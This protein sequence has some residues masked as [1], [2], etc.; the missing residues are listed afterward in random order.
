MIELQFLA[1]LLDQLDLALD[2]LVLNDR[3]HDRFALILIDNAAELALR[4]RIRNI[5]DTEPVRNSL[6]SVDDYQ[7]R[8]RR[9]LRREFD[10]KVKFGV[11]AGWLSQEQGDAILGLHGF[12]NTSYH[13]GHRH[14]GV[15]HSVS[16]SYLRLVCEF[17]VKNETRSYSSYGSDAISYRA[18]KYLGRPGCTHSLAT[19]TDA[20]QKVL[21]VSSTFGDSLIH[22][23]ASDLDSAI[24]AANTSISFISSSSD[25]PERRDWAVVFAQAFVFTQDDDANEKAQAMG[26]DPLKDKQLF[27]WLIDDYRKWPFL[28]DPVPNWRNRL[29]SLRS[30]KSANK[31]IK[32]YC[33]FM[34]QTNDIRLTLEE[35]ESEIDGYIDLQAEILR[36]K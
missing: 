20:F 22:D 10:E 9:A 5:A 32:K 6:I 3:N 2:Q 13:Q 18:M 25:S 36:G 1:D 29:R 15:L 33:D 34:K 14:E 23:L 35:V 8:L 17:L 19:L 27:D 30:E 11:S 16:V 12:R 7:K 4:A 28:R 26:F 21:D 24:E 31:A